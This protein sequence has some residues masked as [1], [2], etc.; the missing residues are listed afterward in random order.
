MALN[1][2]GKNT[3]AYEFDQ[4]DFPALG[5]N[6]PL[7]NR[8]PSQQSAWT[9]TTRPKAVLGKSHVDRERSS[10]DMPVQDASRSGRV[11]FKAFSYSDTRDS[12]SANIPQPQPARIARR[13]QAPSQNT[14]VPWLP[15]YTPEQ[16]DSAWA[17][18]GNWRAR[19]DVNRQEGRTSP[20]NDARRLPSSSYS[21]GSSKSFANLQTPR[22][23]LARDGNE[24][25]PKWKMSSNWRRK[26]SEI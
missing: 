26:K 25:E 19:K 1:D 17:K 6:K 13:R 15:R 3:N 2:E 23:Q 11:L 9:T 5:T 8:T 22:N 21:S 4:T 12:S 14:E 10:L 20:S 24:A 16:K 18:N 7:T